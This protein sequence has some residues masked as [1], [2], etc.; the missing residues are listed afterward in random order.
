LPAPP[1]ITQFNYPDRVSI[2]SNLG[3]CWG[4]NIGNPG[5]IQ[6]TQ[7]HPDSLYGQGATFKLDLVVVSTIHPAAPGAAIPNSN[8]CAAHRTA[9]LTLGTSAIQS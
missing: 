8:T 5:D 2:D 4:A 7:H 3:A 1:G 9:A 6:A